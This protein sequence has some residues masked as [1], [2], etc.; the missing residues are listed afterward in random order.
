MCVSLQ[1]EDITHIL[2]TNTSGWRE[3]GLAAHII[4][5]LG[6][7][8]TTAKAELNFNG[9]SYTS[10]YTFTTLLYHVLPVTT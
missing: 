2:T 1:A 5:A 10:S 6:L 7:P 9:E 3:P 8:L 4:H